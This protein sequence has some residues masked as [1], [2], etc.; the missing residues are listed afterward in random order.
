MKAIN[1]HK[2]KYLNFL[3]SKWL[4][5]WM[6]GWRPC[7]TLPLYSWEDVLR[8]SAHICANGCRL[9]SYVCQI[10]LSTWKCWKTHSSPVFDK[11]YYKNVLAHTLKKK[12]KIFYPLFSKQQSIHFKQA[13]FITIIII[14]IIV[15][16]YKPTWSI[17]YQ[18]QTE[19]TLLQHIFQGCL[20][21]MLTTFTTTA[22]LLPSS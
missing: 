3:T 5:F 9:C 16:K 13:C 14:I 7:V 11:S 19:N 20:V 6:G 2:R 1:Q 10:H 15:I 8:L 21:V 17:N 22:P 18:K 4:L 12:T